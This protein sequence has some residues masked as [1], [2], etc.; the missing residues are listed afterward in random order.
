MR[1]KRSRVI[2]R[3]RNGEPLVLSDSAQRSLK[4][5]N[6]AF[7]I[8]IAAYW[9]LLFA[10]LFNL[11]WFGSWPLAA[12]F[13]VPLALGLATYFGA[14]A[15]GDYTKRVRGDEDIDTRTHVWKWLMA[16]VALPLFWLLQVLLGPFH[17][18]GFQGRA[19][20]WA[21]AA[22]LGMLFQSI[23]VGPDIGD[24]TFE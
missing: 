18:S 20:D 8:V 14:R 11:D 23:N 24:F 9:M 6:V 10:I 2:L 12:K 21:I 13:V 1:A 3:F 5:L 15:A 7:V 16:P 17:W 22:F 4:L 19:A